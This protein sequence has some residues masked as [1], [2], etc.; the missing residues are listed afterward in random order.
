LPKLNVLENL[1]SHY[2]SFYII[3]TGK[4]F[5][6][7][8]K[9]QTKTEKNTQQIF[10]NSFLSKGKKKLRAAKPERRREEE[11]TVLNKG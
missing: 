1:I 11:K 2:F 8:I 6:G 7:I 5:L 10:F 4:I 9:T 3:K